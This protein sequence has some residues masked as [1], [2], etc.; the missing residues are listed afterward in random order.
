MAKIEVKIPQDEIRKI[1]E[2]Y[3][4]TFGLEHKLL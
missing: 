1:E 4:N 3:K 2:V